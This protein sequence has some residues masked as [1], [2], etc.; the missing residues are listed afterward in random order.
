[1]NKKNRQIAIVSLIVLTLVFS[2]ISIWIAIR[3]NQNVAPDDSE[4]AVGFF[5]NCC[6]YEDGQ[7]PQTGGSTCAEGGIGCT[8]LTCQG[9][10]V[11]KFTCDGEL[12]DC[13]QN[14]EGP[15][16]T[17][18][19]G[20][21]TC[22]KSI[23]LIVTNKVCD[24]DENYICG[25]ADEL[26]YIVYFTGYC[27]DEAVCG[28]GQEEFGEECDDGNL[29]NG[30]GCDNK[31]KITTQCSDG[32][33]NDND[34]KIDCAQGNSDPGCFEDGQGGGTCD[35][36]IDEERDQQTIVAQCEDGIDNDSDGKTDCDDA[37][38]Y[39]NGIIVAGQCAITDS[40]EGD[41]PVTPVPVCGNNQIENGEQ[42][43]DGNKVKGD[44]CSDTCQSTT[45][46]GDGVDNDGDGKIDCSLGN[47]DL[48]CFTDGNGGGSCNATDNDETNVSPPPP[49][50]VTDTTNNNVLPNTAIKDNLYI[51]QIILGLLLVGVGLKLYNSRSHTS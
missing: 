33:D 48:G 45:K 49:I 19:I 43:D 13:T 25:E 46:C 32:I 12:G 7:C 42:C 35:T 40:N 22:G 27:S 24:D 6:G 18:S 1:M 34:G 2:V 17:F 37:G 5:T 51:I 31:C 41:E 10:F 26:D 21:E 8:G 20:N 11:Y 39:P 4:A 16:N 14:M 50:P 47:E 29:L 30:D 28:N 36:D 15:L 23:K 44:G 9:N 38:C 3:V